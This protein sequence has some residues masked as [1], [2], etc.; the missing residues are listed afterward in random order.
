MMQ[1]IHHPQLYGGIPEGSSSVAKELER[2][3]L[4]HGH[5]PNALQQPLANQVETGLHKRS[6]QYWLS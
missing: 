4:L 6:M 5:S 3:A 2:L 1:P